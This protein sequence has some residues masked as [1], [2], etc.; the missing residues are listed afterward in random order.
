MDWGAARLA[1]L[2][3]LLAVWAP[4]VRGKTAADQ[5]W[6]P[7]TTCLLI[8]SSFLMKCENLTFVV[9]FLS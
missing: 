8:I 6:G 2:C 4:D 9:A 5:H 3:L 7:V 1:L